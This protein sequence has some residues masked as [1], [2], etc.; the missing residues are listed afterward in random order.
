MSLGCVEVFLVLNKLLVLL[1]VVFRLSAVVEVESI[2]H[3]HVPLEV[4]TDHAV[5]IPVVLDP[6]LLGHVEG[7]NGTRQDFVELLLIRVVVATADTARHH[8]KRLL[9]ERESD[10]LKDVLSWPLGSE[11]HH[12]HA[13][14]MELVG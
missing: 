1:D 13:E 9:G 12:D 11:N 7:A 6:S 8:D 2:V 5:Q 3:H 4:G 10:H 14:S